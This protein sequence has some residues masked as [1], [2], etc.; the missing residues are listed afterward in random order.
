MKNWKIIL[1]IITIWG[2]VY[3]LKADKTDIAHLLKDKRLNDNESLKLPNVKHLK[4]I[5]TGVAGPGNIFVF[6]DS[7]CQLYHI[8]SHHINYSESKNIREPLLINQKYWVALHGFLNEAY[9]FQLK[10]HP[11]ALMPQHIKYKDDNFVV[12][13]PFDGDCYYA[14]NIKGNY[15]Y[16]LSHLDSLP[17][18]ESASYESEAINGYATLNNIF[19][20]K[21]H[22]S[23]KST[24]NKEKK[25]QSIDSTFHSNIRVVDLKDLWKVND[26][27]ILTFAD[28]NKTYYAAT[29]DTV[30]IPP[31]PN[32]QPIEIGRKYKINI[33]P[34]LEILGPVSSQ[35]LDI[36]GEIKIN[37]KKS[38][39]VKLRDVKI[40]VSRPRNNQGL[41]S[42]IVGRWI[43][44]IKDD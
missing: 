27:M 3:N 35:V 24:I 20:A 26:W 8:Y 16:P 2:C 32:A 4:L 14:S 41:P 9:G 19:D 1:F 42:N 23:P 17:M 34:D 30:P 36:S 13:T 15:V 39:D 38:D 40:N 11:D 29:R 25:L 28:E 44:P 21:K 22:S 43:L 10:M 33:I 31:C 18:F 6:E 5:S 12:S 37:P 7:L